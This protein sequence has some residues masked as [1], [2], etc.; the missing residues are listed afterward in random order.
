MSADKFTRRWSALRAAIQM[1]GASRDQAEALEDFVAAVAFLLTDEDAC[2]CI[3]FI[4]QRKAPRSGIA[5]RRRRLM[6]QEFSN[7]QNR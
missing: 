3:A 6:E 4:H 1:G 7:G 2:K 5:E